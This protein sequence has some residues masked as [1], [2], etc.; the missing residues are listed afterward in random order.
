MHAL[1]ARAVPRSACFAAA[2]LLLVAACLLA[3]TAT[4]A[5]TPAK[6][7]LGIYHWGANYTVSAQPSLLDG[8]QQIQNMG[9]SVI[10]LAMSPN[11]T[12]DY[13]GENFGPGAINTLIDLARTSAFRQVF[14]MPFKTYIVM[15]Y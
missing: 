15:T 2:A 8:A 11:Y 14:Q 12:S 7:G 4:A 13:P 1:R 5:P 6:Q 3:S 9:A 10:S